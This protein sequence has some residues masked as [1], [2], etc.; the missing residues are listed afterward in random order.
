VN[1]N[2]GYY[3]KALLNGQIDKYGETYFYAL[4]KEIHIL[5]NAHFI[6]TA[7]VPFLSITVIHSASPPSTS[8]TILSTAA[9]AIQ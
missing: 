7:G 5:H 8:P 1:T 6:T 3:S 2:L 4:K 9:N